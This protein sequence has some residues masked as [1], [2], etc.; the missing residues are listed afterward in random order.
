MK[1]WE[2]QRRK[3]A[4][5]MEGVVADTMPVVGCTAG[6][7]MNRS[8]CSGELQMAFQIVDIQEILPAE[9]S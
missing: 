6:D 9:T 5:E 8:S 4:E 7:K 2:V 1:L 3:I